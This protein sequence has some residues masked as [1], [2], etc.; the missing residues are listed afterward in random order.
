MSDPYEA[1]THAQRMEQLLENLIAAV[2]ENTDVTRD[3][4][5]Q[6]NLATDY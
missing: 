1:V 2:K 3:L 4:L 5:E 6:S